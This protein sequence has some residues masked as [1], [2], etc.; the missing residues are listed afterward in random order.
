MTNSGAK[1]AV[2]APETGLCQPISCA[3]ATSCGFACTHLFKGRTGPLVVLEDR[4][5]AA[6]HP[7]LQSQLSCS[8]DMQIIGSVSFHFPIMKWLHDVS[9]STSH[10]VSCL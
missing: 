8:P 3:L 9:N 4:D 1:C 2:S 7:G 5:P 10:S 6:R